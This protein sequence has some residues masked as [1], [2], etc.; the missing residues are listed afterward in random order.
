MNKDYCFALD[1]GVCFLCLVKVKFPDRYEKLKKGE[2]VL[3]SEFGNDFSKEPLSNYSSHFKLYMGDDDISEI[4]I[5]KPQEEWFKQFVK[6]QEKNKE[7]KGDNILPLLCSQI[8][9]F[10]INYNKM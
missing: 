1:K 6:Y 9:A 3:F 5:K 10:E 2:Q 8:D 7:N 4:E